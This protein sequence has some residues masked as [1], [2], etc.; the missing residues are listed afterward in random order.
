[1]ISKFKERDRYDERSLKKLNSK[2]LF[3][4]QPNGPLI[5]PEAIRKPYI[6]YQNLVRKELKSFNQKHKILELCSG[7]GEFSSELIKSKAI[8]Y[9][10]DISKYSLKILTKRFSNPDNLHIKECDM[11][12]IPFEKE[13]FDAIFCAGS[14]S[15][16]N[17]KIVLDE[18][19]RVLKKKGKFI[20]IDSFNEN[21]IYIF[22]RLLNI[23][24]G[25]RT[26]TTLKRIPNF[27]LLR[28]YRGKFKIVKVN[29]FGK[30]SWL[31][32]LLVPL[33]GVKRFCKLSE[34]IDS[35]KYFNYLSFKII[36]EATKG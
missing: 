13:Y 15:Y 14:L 11:E 29:Y 25:R 30:I 36:I 10:T 6:E 20:C 1:M 21:P 7:T 26:L 24:R 2:I 23:I 3:H 16:G 28:K 27:N 8:L 19:F 5:Y 17:T 4:E 33:M 18:I 32:P 31:Y 9:A 22:Y 35:L 12:N 34:S